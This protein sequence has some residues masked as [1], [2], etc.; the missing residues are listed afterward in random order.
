VLNGPHP[1]WGP[2]PS[3]LGRIIDRSA[4]R[5]VSRLSADWVFPRVA[6]GWNLTV[7]QVQSL[8]GATY[9]FAVFEM[10]E[11]MDREYLVIPRL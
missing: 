7:V 10:L 2:Q 4:R 3:S 6:S 9:E 8:I 5:I 1:R 11:I